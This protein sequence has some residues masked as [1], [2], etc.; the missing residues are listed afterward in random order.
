MTE[1]T[2]NTEQPAENAA[3]IEAAFE[4]WFDGEDASEAAE[5]PAEEQTAEGEQEEEA[6]EE[7]QEGGEGERAEQQ[8]GEGKKGWVPF[9]RFKEVNDK[10]KAAEDREAEKDKRLAELEAKVNNISDVKSLLEPKKAAPTIDDELK[11]YGI[12]PASFQD[13]FDESGNLEISAK[14]QKKLALQEV[15]T[16]A[17]IN[18]IQTQ[19]TLTR[20]RNDIEAA[21]YHLQQSGQPELSEM[22]NNGLTLL[23]SNQSFI[24]Q[25][26]NPQ[27]TEAQA[28]EAAYNAVMYELA[29]RSTKQSK[30]PALI[31]AEMADKLAKRLNVPLITQKAVNKEVDEGKINLHN[32]EESK[33]RAGKPAI[34]TAPKGAVKVD[35]STSKLFSSF[36]D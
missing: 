26:N 18:Q 4:D 14:A 33:T 35:E 25:E 3:A 36:C 22:L 9:E 23:V 12:D 2:E 19:T 28:D 20:T 8:K 17:T 16:K 31:A 7:T 11:Q 10:F 34:T 6:P 32:R 5:Q 13:E 27:L 24:L 21:V 1:A 30:S 29:Q 15:K